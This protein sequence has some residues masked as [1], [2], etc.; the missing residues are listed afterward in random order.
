M[1]MKFFSRQYVIQLAIINTEVHDACMSSTWPHYEWVSISL[2]ALKWQLS[3]HLSANNATDSQVAILLFLLGC[4]CFKRSIQRDT[5]WW[6]TEVEWFCWEIGDGS[7]NPSE[8]KKSRTQTSDFLGK[9][10]W[11]YTLG[12]Q[13]G[14]FPRPPKCFLDA[15]T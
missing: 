9:C 15:H 7:L 2:C 11:G 13:Q 10:T 3:V 4:I 12:R 8:R 5:R 6:L 1:H 14:I